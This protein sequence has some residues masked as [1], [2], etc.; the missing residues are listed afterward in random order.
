[1]ALRGIKV[2]IVNAG[3]CSVGPEGQ[4]LF[5][6]MAKVRLLCTLLYLG[7]S[8]GNVVPINIGMA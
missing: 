2:E 6:K 4:W 5:A 8:K 7:V 1:M 3:R